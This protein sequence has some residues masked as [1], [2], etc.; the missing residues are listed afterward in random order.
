MTL[1]EFGT[2]LFAAI[3]TVG[4]ILAVQQQYA[5]AVHRSDKDGMAQLL[6]R[7]DEMRE[8]LRGQIEKLTDAD[9][10]ELVRHYPWV[11]Q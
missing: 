3:K 9:A 5:G 4:G 11:L 8:M 1:D 2:D 10:A 6:K 7:R